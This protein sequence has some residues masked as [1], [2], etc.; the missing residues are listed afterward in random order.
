[1]SNTPKSNRRLTF[2]VN[3]GQT[4]HTSFELDSGYKMGGVK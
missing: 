1:M 2:V 4:A 3:V